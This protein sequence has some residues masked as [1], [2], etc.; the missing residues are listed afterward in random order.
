MN[1]K[2][3]SRNSNYKVE[4]NEDSIVIMFPSNKRKILITPIDTEGLR[5]H[6]LS[7]NFYQNLKGKLISPWQVP[8]TFH[9]SET[10]GSA[11]NKSE[12]ASLVSIAKDIGVSIEEASKA[13]RI[14]Q[15]LLIR[16]YGGK[17]KNKKKI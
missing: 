13:Q 10:S 16:Y 14:A 6:R 12:D 8:V 5:R 7:D 3:P 9:I 2:N 17:V 11:N 1:E 4:Q 15:S